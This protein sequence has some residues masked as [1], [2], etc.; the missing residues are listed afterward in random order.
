MLSGCVVR[1]GVTPILLLMGAR[2]LSASLELKQVLLI[3]AAMPAAVFPIV[4]AR[5]YGGDT[6]TAV[7]VVVAT[8]AIGFLTIPMWVR[9]GLGFVL[10]KR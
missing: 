10:G 1:C 7:R 4:L 2:Y 3:E 8:S 9:F 5:H 6:L